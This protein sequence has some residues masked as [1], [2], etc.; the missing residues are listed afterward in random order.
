M[1]IKRY[2]TTP[3]EAGAKEI[4]QTRDIVSEILKFGVSQQQILRIAYL[5]SLELENREAMIDRSTS[6]KKYVDELGENPK[7]S[8]IET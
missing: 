5:L 1:S 4:S 3:L 2:G 6:I 8:V 7:K